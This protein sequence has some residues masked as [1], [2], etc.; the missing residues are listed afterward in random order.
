MSDAIL[1]L[2]LE[3]GNM[4]HLLTAIDEQVRELEQ[5]TPPNHELLRSIVDY[6]SGFPDQCHH[7]KEDLVFRKLERRA[8]EVAAKVDNLIEEHHQLTELTKEFATAVAAAERK[9]RA[10]SEQLADV[11]RRFT[12]R[13]RHHMAMEEMYFFPAALDTLSRDDWAEIDFDMFDRTDPLF[14]DSNEESFRALRAIIAR[15]AHPDAD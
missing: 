4:I 3:H 6:I 12:Q 1:M 10:S 15:L 14:D 2:R 9:P 8:P 5:G 7:P 11:M 13:Y